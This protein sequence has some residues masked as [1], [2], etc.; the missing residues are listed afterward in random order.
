MLDKAS[1]KEILKDF[2][3]A[4]SQRELLIKK[5]RDVLKLS[6]QL[7]YSLHREDLS[8]AKSLSSEIKKAFGELAA[9]AEK[10]PELRYSGS[11]KIGAQ[12]Y[13]EAMCYYGFV[14]ESRLPAHKELKV[15]SNSYLFGLC[16][17]TGEL[18]RK[19]INDSIKGRF[20][21]ALKI[22]EVVEEIY[23][24]LLQ[25]DFRESELRK[26]F[27]SIKYDMKRLDDVALSIKLKGSS[28]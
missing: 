19:A 21:S 26:K 22:K 23:G 5:S 11:F 15:D 8:S 4:D 18:V 3:E 2:N 24:E 25:F 20:D 16:D 28:Q 13:V 12:E 10:S 17:L 27:D 14:A 7:I 9:I 1:L 6:K